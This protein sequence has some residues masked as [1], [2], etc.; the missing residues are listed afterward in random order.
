MSAVAIMVEQARAATQSMG[1]H[2]F[3]V[4]ARREGAVTI[5][6]RESE[7]GSRMGPSPVRCTCPAACSSSAPTRRVRHTTRGWVPIARC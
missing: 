4:A 2:E 1:P 6:V 5:D 7:N 3:A